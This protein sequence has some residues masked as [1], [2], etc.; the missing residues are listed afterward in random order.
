MKHEQRYRLERYSSLSEGDHGV[1]DSCGVALSFAG[2]TILILRVE[3][4]ISNFEF[5]IVPANGQ[6]TA[7]SSSSPSQ[8]GTRKTRRVRLGC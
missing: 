5:S 4:R 1:S 8:S 2:L 6:L 3:F 7:A